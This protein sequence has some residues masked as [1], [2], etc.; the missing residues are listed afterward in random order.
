MQPKD[1]RRRPAIRLPVSTTRQLSSKVQQNRARDSDDRYHHPAQPRVWIHKFL[2]IIIGCECLLHLST[3]HH[4]QTSHPSLPK[5]ALQFQAAAPI[6]R[7]VGPT[8]CIPSVVPHAVIAFGAQSLPPSP[9]V[10]PRFVLCD[11]VAR[12]TSPSLVVRPSVS[13]APSQPFSVGVPPMELI[14]PPFYR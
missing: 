14:Q 1:L 6:G 8:S 13:M 5:S 10:T 11:Q 3:S 12:L 9:I 4:E 7:M 2:Q